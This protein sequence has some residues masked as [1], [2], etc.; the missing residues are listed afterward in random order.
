MSNG[1]DFE[2][3]ISIKGFKQL[4][5]ILKKTKTNIT[6]LERHGL[7]FFLHRYRK[8]KIFFI[9]VFV[10]CAMI[11]LL[12]NFVW[13]IHI[14]GNYSRTT[15]V[16]LGY[17]EKEGIVHG[18]AKNRVDCK[19]IATL[20]RAQFD[21]IIWVSAKIKGTRLII[22]VQENTDTVL[23]DQAEYEPSDLIAN[24]EG[25]VTK[26]I[27]RA[28]VP[29][30]I[31]GDT[32]AAGDLLVL[33]RLDITDDSGTVTRYEYCA[34]DADIYIQTSYPY[35]D[36]FLLE[37]EDKEYIEESKKSYN[38]QLFG[39]NISLFKQ[40]PTYQTYDVVTDERQ[41]KLTEN[42]Y[43]PISIGTS[44]TSEYISTT[45]MYTEEE[46]AE[47]AKQNLILFNEKLKEK[48]V[49][50]SENSVRIEMDEKSC[51]AI[52]EVI[53]IEKIGKRINTEILE[54]PEE[55]NTEE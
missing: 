35:E 38:I 2:M 5:P 52:G 19:E 46:A 28:G 31:V 48:G 33:G 24:R 30:V 26:I 17:L 9:G 6:I 34:A 7:P 3:C 55:G 32:V 13:N 42:F 49:Q 51:T 11:F 39:Y 25:V 4:K 27:T 20:L 37:Y 43:L 8:R 12:S 14:E 18:I 23:V 40:Q 29:Q 15:E 21:D 44:K 41:L 22:E 54:T 53:V 47:I 1:N 45:K 36:T 10:C 16:I 50:I